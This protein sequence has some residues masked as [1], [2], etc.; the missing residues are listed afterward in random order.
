MLKTCIGN[1]FME[2]NRYNENTVKSIKEGKINILQT[3]KCEAKSLSNRNGFIQRDCCK[4]CLMLKS[5]MDG[6]Y[7]NKNKEILIQVGKQK[8]SILKVFSSNNVVGYSPFINYVVVSCILKNIFKEK[9]HPAKVP[10]EWAYRCNNNINVIVNK[11]NMRNIKRKKTISDHDG[12]DIQTLLVQ[13]I[14]LCHF[15][16]L[17]EFRH[18]EPSIEYVNIRFCKLDYIMDTISVHDN[19]QLIIPPSVY[20]SITY[21][22]K[23]Y[24]YKSRETVTKLPLEN[25]DVGLTEYHPNSEYIENRIIYNK[26][27]NE[28]LKFK[29]YNR[30]CMTYDFKS[31][32][33][34]MFFTSI[35]ADTHYY[36]IAQN[37]KHV[38]YMWKGIWKEEEYGSIM[39]ELHGNI[40][41]DYNHLLPI[42]SKYY[43]RNDSLAFALK[44]IQ[45][46]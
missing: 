16:S 2:W 37:N 18:G 38:M 14:L 46:L 34:V 32:D 21:K 35:M 20:S 45:R 39:K 25:R 17:Y 3:S 7:L 13:L 12:L 26:I 4:G 30:E 19:K 1:I 40:S 28:V 24:W 5:I 10:Y 36:K 31:F 33:F 23:R 42:V 9:H 6:F 41:N 43:V 22:G 29:H 27:G 15:Y 44:Y 8:G 11:D